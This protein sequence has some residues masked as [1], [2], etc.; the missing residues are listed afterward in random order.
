MYFTYLHLNKS[1]IYTWK[2][3][4]IKCNIYNY[5]K[6]RYI[7]TYYL[8][9]VRR[10][11]SNHGYV[12]DSAN[13]TIGK[14]AIGVIGT[15]LVRLA[16]I[17]PWTEQYRQPMAP[18]VPLVEAMAPIVPLV[19]PMA[20]MVPLVKMI[21]Q[22]PMYRTTYSLIQAE[23]SFLS[24]ESCIFSFASHHYVFIPIVS[25]LSISTP[26]WMTSFSHIVNFAYAL[27]CL[28]N[29]QPMV[30]NIGTIGATSGTNGRTLDG[31]GMPVVPLRTHIISSLVVSSLF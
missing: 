28:E 6:L 10:F 8:W 29:W 19:E 18:M 30:G 15:P 13:G 20:Q 5:L 16:T 4:W 17:E 14:F 24:F 26:S 27:G 22:W 25:I 3:Q 12:R 2:W 21:D 11:A 23:I 9:V 1:T 31:I 7:S